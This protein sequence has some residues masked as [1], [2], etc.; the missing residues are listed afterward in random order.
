MPFWKTLKF[1]LPVS[2]TGKWLRI[3]DTSLTG[4]KDIHIEGDQKYFFNKEY[5]VAA[6]S[7][8]ILIG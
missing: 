3:V 2:P 5:S 1:E 6:R 8:V 4:N 7:I